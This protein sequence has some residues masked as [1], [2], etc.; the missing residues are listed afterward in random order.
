EPTEGIQPSLVDRLAVTLAVIARQDGIG[1]LLVEQNLDLALGLADRVL[2]MEKGRIELVVEAAGLADA[3][4]A[5]EARL[6]I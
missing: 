6:S 1:L 3:L 5:L 2:V 4:P